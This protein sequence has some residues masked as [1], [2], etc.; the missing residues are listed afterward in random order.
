[1]LRCCCKLPLSNVICCSFE[2]ARQLQ[3]EEDRRRH[4]SRQQNSPRNQYAVSN[5]SRQSHD[6]TE[7]EKK[8]S[9]VRFS[10]YVLVLECICVV[11]LLFNTIFCFYH[12]KPYL[13][14]KSIILN[15]I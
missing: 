7:Q 13:V 12:S 1:M 3:E 9:N 11:Q 6:H 2:L 5:D 8:N 14:L 4:G 15:H 10:V